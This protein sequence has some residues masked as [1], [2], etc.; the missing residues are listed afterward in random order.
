MG[1]HKP[2]SAPSFLATCASTMRH[3]LVLL[4]LSYIAVS[5]LSA[6]VEDSWEERSAPTDDYDILLAKSDQ[7]LEQVGYATMSPAVKCNLAAQA[8][9]TKKYQAEQKKSG[10]RLLGR[11][12]LLK[13]GSALE[14]ATKKK[15]KRIAELKA[16]L[17]KC[18]MARVKCRQGAKDDRAKKVKA[19]TVQNG[20]GTRRRGTAGLDKA[21]VKEAEEKGAKSGVK[22]REA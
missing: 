19:D 10:R 8:S 12:N 7:D 1:R 6:P 11:G 15:A 21:K 20:W 3:L 14:V 4:A 16:P 13:P 9:A 2:E 22:A 18:C 5:T 17:F